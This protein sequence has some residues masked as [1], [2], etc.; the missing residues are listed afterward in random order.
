MAVTVLCFA[1]DASGALREMARVLRP[2]GRL[3]IGELGRWSLWAATRRI[4]GWLGSPAWRAARF[5]SAPEL[6]VLVERAGIEVETVRGAV[7][8]PPVGLLTRAL[9]PVDARLGRFT[10]VGAAFVAVSGTRA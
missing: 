6:Q 4:R 8:Y 7:F 1:A 10:T 5:R 2:G 9:A 3:V